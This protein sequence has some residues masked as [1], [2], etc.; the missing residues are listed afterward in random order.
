M[1]TVGLLCLAAGAWSGAWAVGRV[2]A[3]RAAR[4]AAVRAARAERLARPAGVRPLFVACCEVWVVSRGA[5]H[6]RTCRVAGEV[7]G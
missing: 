4:A 3:R 2:E 5:E 7:R 6:S 1:S